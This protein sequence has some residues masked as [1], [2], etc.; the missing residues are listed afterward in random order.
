MKLAVRSF[1]KRMSFY[2]LIC[3]MVLFSGFVSAICISTYQAMREEA[4]KDA[5][6]VLES[7][8]GDVEDIF[9]SVEKSLNSLVWLVEDNIDNPDYLTTIT[10]EFVESDTIAVACMIAFEPYFY[11]NIGEYFGP[12]SF[13][14]EGSREITTLLLGSQAYDYFT[15]DWY[16]IPLRLGKAMWSE[17]YF[18]T[19]GSDRLISTYSIPL[20]KDGKVIGVFTADVSLTDIRQ[21]IKSIKPYENSYCILTGNSGT[22]ISHP[23]QDAILNETLFS[24][25]YA[26]DKQGSFQVAKDLMAK[27]SGQREIKDYLGEKCF[28]T[29]GPLHNGW[30]LGLI[31]SY[32]DVFKD[33]NRFVVF[34]ILV[35][36]AGL[37][38]LYLTISIIIKRMSAPITE[39]SLAA[40]NM[41][42]GNFKAHIPE[43]N[44]LDELLQL[45]NAMTYLQASINIYIKKLKT[46]TAS[47]QRYESELGIAS[48]IQ[49][50]MLSTDFK[51]AGPVDLHAYLHPAKEVGGDLYDFVYR[52]NDDYL[53]FAVGDVS[54]KGVPAAMYMTV[55]RAAFRF[56]T[57]LNQ[58]VQ[59]LV[60]TVNNLIT[61]S[62]SSQM[63]VTFFAARL[64]LKTMVMEY[65]NAGHNPIIII[66]E[67]GDPAYLKA[68]SNLA[69]GLMEDFPYQGESIQLKKGMR[70]LLYTDGVSE[71][72][73]LEKELFGE[74]RLLAF[75][76]A[77]P[78]T[79]SSADFIASLIDT[80]H[81]FTEGN[82]QNDDIT[83]LTIKL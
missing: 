54:G 35:M 9:T 75:A 66:D 34:I 5:S 14:E 33:V 30:G 20:R 83:V 36:L 27:K 65:C 64:N 67:K 57:T 51:S 50:S 69:L 79:D 49:D 4:G 74:D 56:S 11:P 77:R 63:F 59:A 15:M 60:S 39:F 10:R 61:Q 82:E 58:D 41:S 7:T 2:V 76:D 55:T 80:V 78:T 62:N 21:R 40:L 19:D 68:K 42:K 18:D 53:Y 73:N 25:A 13:K 37:L 45:K 71:A 29:Y 44:T 3:A 48:E 70:I 81:C 22:V 32:N 1:S 52:K 43:V 31:C 26:L 16:Q 28:I 46:T 12:Y 24:M 72:E 47:K 17:P 6:K 38:C 23:N 8:I